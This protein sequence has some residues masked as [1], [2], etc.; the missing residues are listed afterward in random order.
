VLGEVDA[1][2]D[3]LGVELARCGRR[4]HTR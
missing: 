4:R 2:A 1:E 3:A